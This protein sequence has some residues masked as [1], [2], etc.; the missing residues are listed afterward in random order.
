M[1]SNINGRQQ[2][3]RGI[4]CVR[5]YFHC[6][7]VVYTLAACV[8][9]LEGLQTLLQWY[10]IYSAIKPIEISQLQRVARLLLQTMAAA[11]CSTAPV[12]AAHGERPL[13]AAYT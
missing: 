12:C 9:D 3:R 10:K 8:L 2:W 4:T 6:T 7:A 11:L 13:A 5:C 1:L